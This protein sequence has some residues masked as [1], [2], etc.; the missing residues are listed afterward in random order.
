VPI[1][2]TGRRSDLEENLAA[3]A[4]TFTADEL[5]NIDAIAPH[6]AAAGVNR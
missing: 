2:G 5:A 4:V 3:A 1:P 6:G